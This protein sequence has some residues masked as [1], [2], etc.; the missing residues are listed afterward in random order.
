MI[1][2]FEDELEK[3][4]LSKENKKKLGIGLASLGTVAGTLYGIR[5]G[6]KL[7]FPKNPA[8]S[9]MHGFHQNLDNTGDDFFT[10]GGKP[11]VGDERTKLIK[12]KDFLPWSSFPE[13]P[14]RL[15]S[16]VSPKSR[17]WNTKQTNDGGFPLVEI[18]RL[19][20]GKHKDIYIAVVNSNT[21]DNM[22]RWSGAVVGQKRAGMFT[23]KQKAQF[24][25][26]AHDYVTKNYKQLN[27][28]KFEG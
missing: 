12:D 17:H 18:K 7:I 13:Y 2:I 1:H 11:I 24:A 4:A 25:R 5:R 10:V 26:E 16:M 14:G 15:K 28:P 19:E 22:G 8:R 6:R 3:I 23:E 20:D 27:F 9:K 21:K